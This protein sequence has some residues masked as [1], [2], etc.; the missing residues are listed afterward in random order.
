MAQESDRGHPTFITLGHCQTSLWRV[1]RYGP[2]SRYP[3]PGR[4][5]DDLISIK[6]DHWPDTFESG[7][8]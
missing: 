7:K 2:R 4:A 1:E 5:A 6:V 3:L 8:D